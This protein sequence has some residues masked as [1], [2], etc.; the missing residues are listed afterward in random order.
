MA[1]VDL[2]KAFDR[3]WHVIVREARKL[4]YSL[5]ILRL[6][7]AAYRA[8]RVV[9]VCGV[10]SQLITPQRSLTAGS[11]FVTTEMRLVLIHI[12][13]AALLVAP[14]GGPRALCG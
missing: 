2:V 12:V 10:F 14:V 5:W 1:L 4:G 7:I 8:D 6:S 11:A 3:V 9:R 13:D